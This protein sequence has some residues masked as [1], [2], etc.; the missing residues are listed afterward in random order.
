[1]L[2]GKKILIIGVTNTNSIAFGIAKSMHQ[3]KATLAFS[4]QYK[5]LK[6]RI[7]NLAKKLDSKI[8][9]ECNLNK[10]KNIK[11]LFQQLKSYWNHFDG[12]VHSVAFAPITSFKKDYINS[13]TKKSFL[14]THE[15][16]SY[17]FVALAKYSQHMLKEGSSLLTLSFLGSQRAIP[18][19]NVMG[20]A[21][22]SLESNIRYMAY[23][24]GQKKIRVNGI[25]APPIRTVSSVSINN[26]TKLMD[27]YENNK[28]LKNELNIY[29]IGNVASFLCS[30]L[31]NGISGQIIYVDAGYS[32]L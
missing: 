14:I 27:Q 15:I 8:V 11:L 24:L 1:M 6:K 10:K 19:Y 17:T 18:Y 3:H 12:I 7:I 22:A 30:D 25:S 31:S 26:F 23:S 13:I 9:I 4:Y 29:D 21:K 32:I 5:K 2:S 16:T 28:P 20:V